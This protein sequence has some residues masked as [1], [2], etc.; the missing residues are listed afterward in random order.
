MVN[1]T[2]ALL[3]ITKVFLGAP[4]ALQERSGSDF[5]G[6]GAGFCAL[7]ASRSIFGRFLAPKWSHFGVKNGVFLLLLSA[8]LG[9]FFGMDFRTFFATPVL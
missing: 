3:E 8:L 5:E 9:S 2:G 4:E 6:L 1:L 7:L